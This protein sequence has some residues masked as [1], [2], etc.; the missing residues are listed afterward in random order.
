[1]TTP[2]TDNQDHEIDLFEFA[3]LS[4]SD[5]V[6]AAPS[7]EPGTKKFNRSQLEQTALAFV[8]SLNPDAVGRNVPTRN[9]KYRATAAGFW[10][11]ARSK[12]SIVTRTVLVMMYNDIGNCFADC[13]GREERLKKI[14]A[15]QQE[16][17]L[18]E[19]TIRHDEPHLAAADDLFSEFRT[20]DY[21]SSTNTAYHTLCR[22]LEREL[23][24][25][26]KGSKLERI[27]QAGV[28][29]QCFLAIPEELAVPDLIPSAWG[30]VGL[31]DSSPHFTLIRDAEFQTNVTPELR[32]GFAFNIGS[33]AAASVCFANGVDR[34]GTLRRPPRKRG[35]L[36]SKLK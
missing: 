8:L 27:R 34:D 10:K 2:I 17:E 23:Q 21:G 24:I 11:H 9:A 7:P 22:K 33:A 6:E 28:A 19:S 3:E 35:K 25:L 13:E 30:I 26:S 36:N 20:W 18:M 32:S 29:D 14:T 4:M 16:K 31:R 12:G 5:K 15:L 1:M